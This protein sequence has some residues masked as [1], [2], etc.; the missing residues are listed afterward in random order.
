MFKFDLQQFATPLEQFFGQNDV[1]DYTRN[2]EYPH[3]VGDDLFPARR[4]QS[5]TVD[6]L[7]EGNRTP[8]IAN[9]S[10]FDSEAE[11]G[12]REAAKATAELAYVKRK[13][14]IKDQD[15]IALT[16]PRNAAEQQYLIN[17]VYND[18]DS[19]VQSILARGEK[20]TMEMLATGKIVDKA[21]GISVNYGVPSDHQTKLTSNN[22]WNSASADILTNLQ[23]WA[24]SLSIQPT[25][26][27]TSKKV[28]RTIMRNEKVKQEIFG[29]ANTRAV[30]LA[31]LDAFMQSQGLPIIRAYDGKYRE[32]DAKG[33]L[34]TKTYFPE[35]AI[36]LMNDDPLGEK[37]FGPTPEEVHLVA[38]NAV[39]ASQIGNVYAKVYEQQQDPVSTWT[40]AS[41]TMLPSFAAVDEVYQATV[42]A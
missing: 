3:L 37:L 29:T 1:L 24:D 31:D 40:L 11:I 23:D 21:H 26:A 12:S 38:A 41:A 6:M 28:L 19:L 35:D 9:Y 5:L 30:G 7:L 32:E 42:L 20:M 2:R 18:I 39:Q 15:I 4:V 25:R 8:V 16:N 27:L 13:K 36:V 10:S 17:Q 22:A 33:K 34:T 14:Q